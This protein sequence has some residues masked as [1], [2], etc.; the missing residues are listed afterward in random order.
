MIFGGAFKQQ[1]REGY[2]FA[3]AE[4]MRG[5]GPA[6]YGE[7]MSWGKNPWIFQSNIAERVGCKVRTVQRWLHEFRERGLLQCW[8]GKRREVPPGA[9][10]PIRCGFSNRAMTAWHAA[11][12]AFRKMVENIKARREQRLKD[13]QA[14]ARGR[15]M[16]A[17]E[18]EAEMLRRYGPGPPK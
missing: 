1:A 5:F 2:A 9:K 16:T 6:I 18:I 11:G 17:E 12:A 14:R 8:R 15:R 10:G 7:L 3:V 4:G 13:R